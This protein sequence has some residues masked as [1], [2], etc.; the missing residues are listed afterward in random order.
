MEGETGDGDVD[1]G[2][3]G[4]AGSGGEAAARAL[5]GEGND[6]AGDEDVV[7]EFGVEARDGEGWVQVVCYFGECK[8]D[9]G[10]EEDWCE[11]D[12]YCDVC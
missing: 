1:G 4:A 5:E 6:V 12:A 10:G 7:V 8:V 11:S 3:G 2:L 9:A